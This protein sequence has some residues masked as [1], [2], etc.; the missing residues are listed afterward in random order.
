MTKSIVLGLLLTIYSI[1]NESIVSPYSLTYTD[2][3]KMSI[4]P[5]SCIASEIKVQDKKLNIAYKH[6]MESILSS[7][8]V[9]LKKVQRLWIRYRD[10]KCGFFYHKESGSGGLTDAMQCELHETM[11]R[12]KE[13]EAL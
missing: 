11:I 2:C 1:A 13:L 3:M 10:E 5:N 4:N 12:T 6:A 8:V 9:T 7:R